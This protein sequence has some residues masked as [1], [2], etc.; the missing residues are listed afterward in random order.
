MKIQTFLILAG[1]ASLA[2][3][4]ATAQT[5]AVNTTADTVDANP[6][7]GV[8][9]DANGQTSLRAAVQEANAL[10]SPGLVR[11][12]LA[13]GMTYTLA[14]GG[15]GE[16]AAAT[17]DLDVACNLRIYGAGA[18]VDAN[19]LDRAFDVMPGRSLSVRQL[20]VRGGC[21]NGESGGG[22]RSAGNLELID[23]SISWSDAT[24]AGASG[25]AVFNDGGN[26]WVNGCTM[27]DNQASR[28]GGAIEANGGFTSLMNSDFDD[29]ATGPMPGNGGG[30]HLTGAGSVLVGWCGFHGNSAAREGGALWNSATGTMHVEGCYI[31]DNAATG[32]AADD[33]GGG[34][35]NDG[36]TMTVRDCEIYGNVATTGSG[37]GG[38][39]FNNGGYLDVVDCAI[40]DNVSN[41]AGGG[42]EA[43]DGLTL[44]TR[45]W[46]RNNMTGAM[47]GNGGGLHLTGAGGVDAF[48]CVFA[49]NFASAE[50]GGMWNSSGGTMNVHTCLLIDNVAS[51]D[52]SD[53]GGGGLFNAGGTL[54]VSYS[55]V[56]GNVADGAA[57]SGGGVLND[58]GW[59][60]MY[61]TSLYANASNRAGGAVEA[62]IGQTTITRSVM[63]ANT[64]G[65]SPGNGGGLHLTGA[66]NV[67]VAD[68]WIVFNSADNEGGGLW[69]SATGTMTVVSTLLFGN[70]APVGANAF[71]DGGTFVLNGNPVP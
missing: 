43:L 13:S 61:E 18:T 52:G 71:N 32:S 34:L 2:A 51:G 8:A 41:R 29:N 10:A 14:L 35:F 68:S 38:G 15:A 24:G 63:I 64:T 39:L 67:D 49:E 44:L 40:D 70:L 11:I 12:Q 9:A 5:F 56:I 65:S 17:G 42:I 58:A 36:G 1:C 55:Y 30:L 54:N 59:L 47:P 20:Q 28:A 19:S 69:N 53:Q 25:G 46:V 45:V 7:D 57:G 26:L 23:T 16:D 22:V 48:Q 21:V 33:G 6:G 31:G 3:T 66:G 50:G 27:H 37:S 4:T 60:T 62:N